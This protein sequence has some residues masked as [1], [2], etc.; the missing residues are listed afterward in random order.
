MLLRTT[1]SFLDSLPSCNGLSNL[2]AAHDIEPCVQDN[3]PSHTECSFGLIRKDTD[4]I[5]TKN[6]FS[7]LW[8]FCTLAF[9]SLKVPKEK[10]IWFHISVLC[11]LC[12]KSAI[13]F[14]RCQ[15]P[16]VTT[17]T[18]HSSKKPA[19]DGCTT[20]NCQSVFC[21]GNTQAAGGV[22]GQVESIATNVDKLWLWHHCNFLLSLVHLVCGGF[23]ESGGSEHETP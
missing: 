4:L 5:F 19:D 22:T 23:A 7:A 11:K 9:K 3:R 6:W 2:S 18:S 8:E 12:K 10:F 14:P 21:E 15:V 1:Q 20:G 17:A 13:T 16:E